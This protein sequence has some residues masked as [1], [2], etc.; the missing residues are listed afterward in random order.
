[1]AMTVT[2]NVWVALN[3]G[4]P[5]SVTITLKKFV[6]ACDCVGVQ[7]KMPLVA[8]MDALGAAP[9]SR[10]NVNGSPSG[11]FAMFVT[12][13]VVPAVTDWSEI[14]ASTGG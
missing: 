4:V 2:A 7:M 12:S 9:A 14:G 10:L 3:G 6:P 1:M 13:K 11:S 8:P 5:L